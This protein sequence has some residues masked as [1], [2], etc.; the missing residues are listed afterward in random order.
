MNY[1]ILKFWSTIKFVGGIIFDIDQRI[2][3]ELGIEKNNY[4]VRM[5][6]DSDVSQKFLYDIRNDIDFSRLPRYDSPGWSGKMASFQP[7]SLLH[8]AE[9][10]I[11]PEYISPWDNCI[12]ALLD[13]GY[14]IVA[15]GGDKDVADVEK[16]YPELLNKY[17]ITN[18][19]GKINMFR[20]IDLVMNHASFVLSCDS[21]SGWYGIASRTKVAVAAGKTYREGTDSAYIEALGN[22]DVYILDYAYNKDNCDTN[23]ARWIKENA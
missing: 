1:D 2:P 14:E 6:L 12:K 19:M 21:W 11:E 18:L 10:D 7:I 13:K 5:T 4:D 22:K 16:Y 9:E 23:L 17:P 20:S 3:I 8:R 15:I